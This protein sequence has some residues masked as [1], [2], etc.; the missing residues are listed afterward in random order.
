MTI[1]TEQIQ[2]HIRWACHRDIPAIV[3]IEAAS[4]EAPGRWGERT[5]RDTLKNKR[6]ICMV[7]ERGCCLVGFAIYQIHKDRLELLNVAVIPSARR[8]GVGAALM[9]KL[10]FKVGS[11][12]RRRLIV[13][14]RETNLDGL[15]FFRSCGLRAEKIVRDAYE[16]TNDDCYE[17]V[18]NLP[19]DE[20]F[21]GIVPAN[22]LARFPI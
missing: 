11:H 13:P 10:M 12:N 17:L 19:D 15:A 14:V 4:Y 9:A 8:L 22:R 5:F 21:T 20:W 7:A 6:C 1:R 2:N 16:S 18:Y 3:A